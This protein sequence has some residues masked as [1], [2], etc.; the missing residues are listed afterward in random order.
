MRLDQGH[1]PVGSRI[2]Q[3]ITH[4]ALRSHENGTFAKVGRNAT[5]E[6]ESKM[7]RARSAGNEMMQ[8]D[9]SNIWMA[10]FSFLH[11]FWQLLRILHMPRNESFRENSSQSLEETNQEMHSLSF[12]VPLRHWQ[13][14]REKRG[15]GGDVDLSSKEWHNSCCLIHRCCTLSRDF[16]WKEAKVKICA[17]FKGR[18]IWYGALLSY[19]SQKVH[20]LQII[21]F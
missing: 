1:C 11:P 17:F 5:C 20:L 12:Y 7:S 19:K 21:C 15:R 16:C 3:L 6:A 18:N 8:F 14:K 9:Q 10:F 13:R 4:L 2:D